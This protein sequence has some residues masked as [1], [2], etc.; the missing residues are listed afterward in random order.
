LFFCHLKRFVF[1]PFSA[2]A[3]DLDPIDL[4]PEVGAGLVQLKRNDQKLDEQVFDG[5]GCS[6]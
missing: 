4:D 1:V 6:I 2:E 3:T 5:S